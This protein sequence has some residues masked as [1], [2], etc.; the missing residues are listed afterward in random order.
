LSTIHVWGSVPVDN[1]KKF[2]IKAV[3]NEKITKMTKRD[4]NAVVAV[5]AAI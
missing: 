1:F 3:A 4:A 5:D 2:I